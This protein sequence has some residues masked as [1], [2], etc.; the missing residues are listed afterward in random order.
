[1]FGH[2]PPEKMNLLGTFNSMH[3]AENNSMHDAEKAITKQ[4]ERS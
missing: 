4:C 1:M 2:K 3:D